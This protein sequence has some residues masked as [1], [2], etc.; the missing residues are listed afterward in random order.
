MS[1]NPIEINES[2]WESIVL[3]SDKPVLVDF[4]APWCG[5]C[6]MISP[7]MDKI[8]KDFGKEL[9]VAKINTDLCANLATVYGVSAMPSVYIFNKGSVFAKI[10]GVNPES[11]YVNELR[12]IITVETYK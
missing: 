11:K 3:N 9:I 8:A 12:K 4:Y 10:I 2:D 7:L 1:E 5:P 6:K